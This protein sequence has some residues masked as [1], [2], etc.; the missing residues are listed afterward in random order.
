VK[1]PVI[2]VFLTTPPPSLYTACPSNGKD[3]E[4]G[5]EAGQVGA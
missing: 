1:N 4:E 5:G 3:E 2:V